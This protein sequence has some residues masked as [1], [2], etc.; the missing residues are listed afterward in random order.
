MK[1]GFSVHEWMIGV[2]FVV[3]LMAPCF[4]AMGMGV[5]DSDES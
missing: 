3:L 2:G 4:I 1:R 5:E